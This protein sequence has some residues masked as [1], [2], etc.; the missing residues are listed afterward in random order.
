MTP[1]PLTHQVSE[2]FPGVHQAV[3]AL[4]VPVTV[5]QLVSVEQGEGFLQRPDGGVNAKLRLP[6]LQQ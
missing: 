4:A 5:E 2:V 3:H 6:N 1:L